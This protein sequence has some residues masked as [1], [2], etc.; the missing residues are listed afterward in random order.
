MDAQTLLRNLA[1]L[2]LLLSGA[3]ATGPGQAVGTERRESQS[4]DEGDRSTAVLHL[5][6]VG[7]TECESPVVKMTRA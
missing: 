3:L 2:L 1:R 6:R 5:F 4:Q 7:Y